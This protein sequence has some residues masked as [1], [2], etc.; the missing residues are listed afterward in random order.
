MAKIRI[1]KNEDGTMTVIVEGNKGK[2]YLS[3]TFA[4][5][6]PKDVGEALAWGVARVVDKVTDNGPKPF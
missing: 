3:E 5:I 4:R 1:K 6:E 2:G